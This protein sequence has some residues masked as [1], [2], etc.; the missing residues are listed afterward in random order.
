MTTTRLCAA[1]TTFLPLLL[2]SSAAV[3][4]ANAAGRESEDGRGQQAATTASVYVVMVKAPAQGVD[5]EA[6]HMSILATVLGS[7]EKAKRALIYS[8]KAA[9]SGFAA[10]LTPAQVAALQKHPDV[11]QALPDVKYTLEDRNHLN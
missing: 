8:Y 6:Y 9:A 3:S 2:L 5:S 4:L 10:K 11:V 7:E 1:L